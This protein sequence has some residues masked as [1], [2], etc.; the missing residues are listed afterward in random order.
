MIKKL[1]QK[2][3]FKLYNF[4]VRQQRVAKLVVMITKYSPKIF[5]T[6]YI[7]TAIY[8]IYNSDSRT[9]IFILIPAAVYLTAKLIPLLYNRRRP[10]AEYS[11]ESLV[12]QRKDHSFPSTHTASSMIIS[13]AV[14]K[15]NFQLGILMVFLAVL[16]AFSRIM[17]GVHYPSDVLGAW[18]IVLM[19]HFLEI[20]I[21][22]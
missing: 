10:F 20:K 22:I 7:S 14:L 15:I 12:K 21:W 11:L 6:I 5:S 4:T 8:L 1:D 16:T 18:V 13:L 17:V 19:L 2:I 3:F 9:K